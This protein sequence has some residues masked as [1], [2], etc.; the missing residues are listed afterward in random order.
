MGKESMLGVRWVEEKAE[1]V[2]RAAA[3]VARGE[4][5]T[6][7][8]TMDSETETDTDEGFDEDW[9]DSNPLYARASGIQRIS[10]L[11]LSAA[12]SR[13]ASIKAA[14]NLRSSSE[15]EN[16]TDAD[17]EGD[18]HNK[19][20]K[21]KSL[22]SGD[23]GLESG[24]QR[25][26]DSVLHY[27]VATHDSEQTLDLYLS[28]IITSFLSSPLPVFAGSSESPHS[29]QSRFSKHQVPH[30]SEEGTT[31]EEYL[32]NVKI[33]VIDKAT[34]VASPKQ[35]GHMTSA[36]PYFHRPLAKLLTAM[37]QNVVKL[38]TAST[39]T[40]L[41]RET[42]AMMHNEFYG[43][44]C[45]KSFYT[46]YMHSFDT[47]L[48]VFTSGGTIANL[49]AMWVARN[50]A[51]GPHSE[52][53][54]ASSDFLFEFKGRRST[55]AFAGV[56][57]EG[58][59]KAL[60]VYG[61]KGAVILGSRML[62]YSFKK[63]VDLLGFGDF[64]LGL[65]DVDEKF[66]IRPDALEKEVL[67]YQGMGYLIVSI[68]GIAGTTETGSIDNLD[69]LANI[70][71]KYKIHFHV[72]AAWGG[73]LIFS[74]E[75]R[76]KLMGIEKADT[77]TV[78]GHKQLY[79]PMGLGL[80]LFANPTMA[81]SI[82]KTANYIIRRESADLGQFTLE[83]SRPAGSL[84]LHAVLHLVGRDG[85]ESL[86]TRSVT[87]VRQMENRLSGHPTR[88]FQTLHEPDTNILLYR[89]IPRVLRDKV[90]ARAPL[91][92]SEDEVISEATRRI[93]ARQ[94]AEGLQGFVS[95][96]RVQ[97]LREGGERR[98][99]DAFRVV[100]ANPLTTW[101]DVE[102]VVAEQLGIGGQIE[103][104]MVDER[105]SGLLAGDNVVMWIGWPFE[106]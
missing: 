83:G 29:I 67:K 71:R 72:D 87:L 57:K 102:G 66:R 19:N 46:H 18:D 93:Q 5:E 7:V 101:D 26:K 48:G 105:H 99:V 39:T 55:A 30:S 104:E 81:S 70:A 75:H 42:I 51:L 56:D 20:V 43:S 35:I 52:P 34:R 1:T 62:H 45:T 32:N 94:A 74:R 40:Y 80:L 50:R 76:D 25:N 31:L 9:A 3:T 53:K 77:I 49:T 59:F 11:T 17:D 90:A 10:S 95:R 82:R 61:Y 89:Y 91:L 69:A 13:G 65:V 24:S 86:V 79:T 14:V 63:A 8:A 84:H 97:V 22:I 6:E 36:L 88:A 68:I 92:E 15:A 103:G 44:V 16:D 38:E 27:F 33:N 78:D 2:L 37:N 96:T 4:I 21:V 85:I 106:I 23:S 41:E 60:N 100:I 12:T 58:L 73:P 98:W 64:G 47:A 54:M 28:R